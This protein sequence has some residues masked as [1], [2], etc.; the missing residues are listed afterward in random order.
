MLRSLT[1]LLFQQLNCFS[2]GIFP[3][4]HFLFM[5]TLSDYCSSCIHTSFSFPTCLGRIVVQRPF[6][7]GFCCL[8]PSP[9]SAYPI[10]QVNKMTAENKVICLVMILGYRYFEL[11]HL[12]IS[13]SRCCFCLST[14]LYFSSARHGFFNCIVD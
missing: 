12:E 13:F 3:E 6:L 14:S 8:S 11:V 9:A 1:V 10:I 7:I 4:A 2:S 5:S